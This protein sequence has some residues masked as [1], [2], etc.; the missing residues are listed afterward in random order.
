MVHSGRSSPGL[1][2]HESGLE[3]GT[4]SHRGQFLNSTPGPCQTVAFAMTSV[5]AL[6]LTQL[7]TPAPGAPIEYHGA[8]PVTATWQDGPTARTVH[9]DESLVADRD[10][11][12]AQATALREKGAM[13]SRRKGRMRLWRVENASVLLAADAA[14]LPVYR[15]E[16][17]AKVRVPIGGVLVV[18]K[19]GTTA[20][21]LRAA[22]GQGTVLE[23]RVVRVE[24]PPPEVFPRCVSLAATAGVAWVQPDWWVSATPK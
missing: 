3:P 15:D 4:R 20:K 11:S 18:P 7:V 16:S 21:A 19:K 24:V 5:L 2:L 17:G 10:G 23:T 14:L 8:W 13:V 9:L 22:L 12:D 6:V 1:T